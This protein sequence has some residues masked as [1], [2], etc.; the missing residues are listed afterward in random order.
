MDELFFLEH[1]KQISD[2]AALGD[3][4]VGEIKTNTLN[5]DGTVA[6]I[7]YVA[8]GTT[9]RTDTFTYST[10]TITE[11]RTAGSLTITKVHHLDTLITEV[12]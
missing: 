9:V 12:S 3:D 5:T 6:S 1:E 10:D 2:L 7:T 4:I 8:S 11:V